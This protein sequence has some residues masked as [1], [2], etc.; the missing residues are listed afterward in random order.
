MLLRCAAGPRGIGV[1]LVMTLLAVAGIA[2][3]ARAGY[4]VAI[5][6]GN[7]TGPTP[8]GTIYSITETGVGTQ[9]GLASISRLNGMATSP[10][11]EI[12]IISRPS[13][14]QY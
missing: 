12:I 6:F 11:G 7:S 1:A 9:I 3:A 8:P 13:S 2:S 14:A 10:S 5:D 4:F